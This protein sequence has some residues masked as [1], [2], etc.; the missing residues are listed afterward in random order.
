MFDAICSANDHAIFILRRNTNGKK[1][2]VYDFAWN[3]VDGLVAAQNF[4]LE[5]G[6]VVYVAEA[7]IVSVQKAIGIL[8]QLALPAQ[9]LKL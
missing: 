6:D 7:P 9:V 5:N 3:K 2:T 1:P 8:F 4:P